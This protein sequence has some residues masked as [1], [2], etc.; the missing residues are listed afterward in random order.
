MLLAMAVWMGEL[1]PSAVAFLQRVGTIG[2]QY[3]CVASECACSLMSHALRSRGILTLVGTTRN[4]PWGVGKSLL[5]LPPLPPYPALRRTVAQRAVGADAEP[6]PM[7]V[8]MDQVAIEA[9]TESLEGT[10]AA[11]KVVTKHLRRLGRSINNQQR[12]TLSRRVLGVIVLRQRLAYIADFL[13][14]RSASGGC[15]V[16]AAK[17]AMRPRIGGG[18]QRAADLLALYILYH[19]GAE[20]GRGAGVGGLEAVHERVTAF[21]SRRR[22]QE[23]AGLEDLERDVWEPLRH[24]ASQRKNA[25]AAAA[26]GQGTEE[27]ACGEDGGGEDG[28]QAMSIECSLPSWLLRRWLQQARAD[29]RPEDRPGHS[30]RMHA[31]ILALARALNQIPP[32]YLRANL[33]ALQHRASP[34]AP[35]GRDALLA[36]LEARGLRACVPACLRACLAPPTPTARTHTTAF[37]VSIRECMHC[38]YVSRACICVS[39]STLLRVGLEARASPHSPWGVE[40]CNGRPSS[41]L[42]LPEWTEGMF[43]V[44]DVGS[45][46]L[47]FA[48]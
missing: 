42:R 16:A 3:K 35:V 37:S 28:V 7:S 20:E 13:D 25:A 2:W 26:A 32:V 40:L 44:Q 34:G 10:V 1:S 30:T 41:G 45:Q 4:S 8:D 17:A 19:E 15:S 46:V 43:E 47:I 29:L 38:V 22:A 27:D 33:L 18:V 21:L 24:A 36:R 31:E 11:D 5:A 23:L 6:G 48:I 12:A 39:L 9:I 14:A